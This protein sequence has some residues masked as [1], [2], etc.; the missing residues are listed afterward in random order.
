MAIDY[1]TPAEALTESDTL[2]DGLIDGL[3][4]L[5]TFSAPPAINI[6]DVGDLPV[7]L[8]TEIDDPT[9]MELTEGEVAGSGVFDQLMSSLGAHIEGQYHKGIIGQS[10]VAAIYIAA[11]QTTLPQSIQFLLT[12]SQSFWA[13]KLTQIQAQNA[14]L[15]RARLIAEIET[16]KLI[17]YRAQAEAY[18]AQV[19]M[20]TA[21]S[22][23]ANSKLQL[24]KT[25]QEINNLEAQMGVTEMAY[26]EGW[27][28]FHDT[29]SDNVTAPTGHTGRDFDLKEEAIVTAQKQQGLIAAQT[30]VQRA[31]TY[32]TNNDA[33][34][35][36]GVIGVQKDLYNQQIASYIL[37]GKNKGVKLVADLWTSAKALD[38]AVQS[39]GPLAGNLMM[40]LNKYLN[41]LEL[42]NAYVNADSPATGAPSDDTDLYTPGDQ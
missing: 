42:P 5:P 38:D 6:P 11:I 19:G 8:T 3:P 37:D 2:F 41:D 27:V 35:V 26:E 25:I 20:L 15:E 29:L 17:A 31:Q 7:D 28:K 9:L 33:S 39:P 30:N 40:A 16:A 36:T 23:F 4:A 24:S 21:Q 12:R 13:A 10:D 32:D 22:T 34:P 18:I 14:Y 1:T